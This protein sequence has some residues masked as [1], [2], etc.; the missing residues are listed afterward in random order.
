MGAIAGDLLQ[1]VLNRQANLIGQRE[2]QR[3]ARFALPNVN[4]SV[5]PVNIVERESHDFAGTQTIRRHKREHGVIALS[6]GR[7]SVDGTRNASIVDQGSDRG[8]CSCL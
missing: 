5:A 3:F 8:S 1:V 2:F 6:D 4:L 7:V